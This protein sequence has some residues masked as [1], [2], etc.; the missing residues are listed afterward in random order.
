MYVTICQRWGSGKWAKD[1]MPRFS[2]PFRKIQNKFPGAA[3]RTSVRLR[4]GAF[5][6]PSPSSP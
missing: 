2:D 4:G 3:V 1:G 5:P 6:L